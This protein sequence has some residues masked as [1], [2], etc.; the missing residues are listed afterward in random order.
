MNI[1]ISLHG[2]SVTVRSLQLLLVGRPVC[3]CAGQW[4]SLFV[5]VLDVWNY[6]ECALK[7]KA[8]YILVNA[9]TS[10]ELIN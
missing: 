7:V 6:I 1:P 8:V 5:V 9:Y 10:K 2:L 3:V 4:S